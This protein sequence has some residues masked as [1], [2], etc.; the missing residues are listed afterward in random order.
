MR[1]SCLLALA[2][3]AAA[4]GDEE[5]PGAT[6]AGGTGST[7]TEDGSSEATT[8]PATTT[9]GITAS[10]TTT[11]TPTTATDTD[12]TSTSSTSTGGDDASSSE[13]T[14]CP[15]GDNGCA[16]DGDSCNSG[17]QC[18]DDVCQPPAACD[19][20]LLEPNDEETAPTLLGEVGDNDD[21]GGSIFGTL[22]SP[23]DV[24][25]YRY[26]GNDTVLGNVD[27]ARFVKSDG[28]VRLCKF[29]E[30]DSGIDNTEFECPAE[31]EP[32]TSPAGRPGCCAPMGI[33]LDDANCSGS[34]DDDMQVYLRVDSGGQACVDYELIY[35]F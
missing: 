3:L 15:L 27:P 33:A 8:A 9:T 17:L 16:C 4:C 2:L 34:L 32:A 25:W 12:D 6:S 20:D 35:H 26:N 23:D 10:G 29:A 19:V 18:V 14:G 24:D 21:N 7:T 30:C 1:C 5:A 22:D 31:T 11:V 13:S 28:G